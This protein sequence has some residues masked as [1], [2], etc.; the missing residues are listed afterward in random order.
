M[1]PTATP[2]IRTSCPLPGLIAGVASKVA[3]KIRTFSH[4]GLNRCWLRM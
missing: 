1:S 2:A 4:G 3:S